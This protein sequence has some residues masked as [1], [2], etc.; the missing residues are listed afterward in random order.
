MV[1]ARLVEVDLR[2]VGVERALL[3]PV[4]DLRADPH[5]G[6]REHPVGD[7][8][9]LGHDEHLTQLRVHR[10]L[11]H[12]SPQLRE[13]AAVVQGAQRVEHLERANE[14]LGGRRVHK[15]EVNEV[16][17]PERFEHQHDGA[18]IR[19]LDLRDR[20]VLELVEV[21]PLGV[22]SEALARRDAAGAAGALVGTR[23]RHRRHD[24]TLHPR[25]RVVR[26]LL[27]EAGV[28]HVDDVVD[29]DRRLRNVGRQH[30][31]PRARRSGLEDFRLLIGGEGRID[32]E[33]DELGDLGAEAA[34]AVLQRLLRR[35]DL[36]LPREEDENVSGAGGLGDV[37]L[38]HGDHR[39]LQVVGLGRLRVHDVDG[40]APPGM[41]KTGASSR[42]SEN[43][44]ASSV[45]LLTSSLRSGRKRAMSFKSPNRMCGCL[46][47]WATSRSS[48][49]TTRDRARPET[50]AAAC[51][52][53]CT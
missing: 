28:D 27:G 16:V 48:P 19:A 47:S 1:A 44:A 24:Q 31:L 6:D 43:F 39:G 2:V 32:R 17:D 45:A 13:L 42:Y 4:E 23:L 53:S 34:R 18:Q 38:E 14:R 5:C 40:V 7:P 49:S 21:R 52:R 3:R 29:R 50:R 11:G 9:P 12:A 51:R 36:L 8:V 33:D 30:H 20:V 10:E 35:L 26:V 22:Q 41:L 15:V 37:D 46:R 25:A